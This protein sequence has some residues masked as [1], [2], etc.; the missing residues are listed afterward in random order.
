M[1]IAVLALSSSLLLI[2]GCAHKNPQT[3]SVPVYTP[4][5][6]S[7][8]APGSAPVVSTPPAPMNPDTVLANQVRQQLNASPQAAQLMRDVQVNAQNGTITLS[9]SVPNDQD[10]QMLQNLVRATPGVTSVNDSL[11]VPSNTSAPII[12]TPETTYPPTGRTSE[13]NQVGATMPGEVF[14]L[15]VQGLTPQDRTLAQQVMDGLRADNSLNTLFPKVDINIAQ[16]KV[17][18]SGTVANQQQHQAVLNAV[19]RSAGENNVVDQL[20][21][22]SE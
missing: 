10:R 8:P 22:Q 20:Q 7:T 14:N 1:K 18:L 12:S 21:V 19:K 16:G 13:T 17:V 15:H 11:Q 6:I 5:V 3:A 9:G 4:S 2:A